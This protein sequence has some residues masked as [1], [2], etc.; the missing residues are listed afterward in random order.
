MRV[1][2]KLGKKGYSEGEKGLRGW[3]KRGNSERGKGSK[4]RGEKGVFEGLCKII[5]IKA[6]MN[7]GLSCKLKSA[8]PDVVP[9]VIPLVVNQKISYP[10]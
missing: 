5:A 6:Y 3:G 7:R 10:N 8:F 9:V 4:R 2:R 1:F